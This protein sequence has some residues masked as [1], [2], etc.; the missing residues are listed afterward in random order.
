MRAILLPAESEIRATGTL[1]EA[2]CRA[3]A[4]AGPDVRRGFE[5]SFAFLGCP[6]VLPPLMAT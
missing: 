1:S 4:R 2:T 6:T 3:F 5:P